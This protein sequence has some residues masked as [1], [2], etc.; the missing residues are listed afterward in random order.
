M[1]TK[2]LLV[3]ERILLESI[4]KGPKD[5]QELS[6]DTELSGNLLRNIVPHLLMKNIVKFHNGKYQLNTESKS[7]WLKI[8]NSSDNVKEEVKDLFI[9]LVNTYF[10]QEKRPA[11]DKLGLKMKKVYLTPSE[12]KL[13]NSYLYN[14]EEFIKGVENDRKL[15]PINSKVSEKKVIIWGHSNYSSLVDGILEAV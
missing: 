15:N 9:S 1:T 6:V 2:G 4:A 3:V 7:E 10:N 14:L 5:I 13:Y 12:E 8:I 11:N